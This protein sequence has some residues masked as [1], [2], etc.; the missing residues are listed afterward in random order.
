[1][2]L[3]QP[4]SLYIHQ[5]KH[6]TYLRMRCFLS[7]TSTKQLTHTT[8]LLKKL[9]PSVL[10]TRCF[11][12]K[13]LSFR[14][15]VKNTQLGHLFEHI[16]LD[17]LC[18]VKKKHGFK[19]VVHS[20]HTTWNWKED[21]RGTFHLFINT[22]QNDRAYFRLALAHTEKIFSQLCRPHYPLFQSYHQ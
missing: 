4:Y 12:E 15:E 8:R 7:L 2:T 11:N 9:V 20:G 5:R 21:E 13:K 1:M 18:E 17:R 10:K 6:T 3:P 19:K 14:K 22:T 16:L